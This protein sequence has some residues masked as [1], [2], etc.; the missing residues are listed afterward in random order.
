MS[1]NTLKDP[2]IQTRMEI[3]R[4][5]GL[6]AP[7]QDLVEQVQQHWP[8][9]VVT[10]GTIETWIDGL[11]QL[12]LYDAKR[13]NR[14]ALKGLLYTYWPY[15]EKEINQFF[16]ELESSIT[17][18]QKVVVVDKNLVVLDFATLQSSL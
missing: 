10:P 5:A 12:G 15:A 16:T 11:I 8:S 6:L 9:R 13:C 18:P 17:P 7:D 14:P 3:L 1:Q 2:L 4:D